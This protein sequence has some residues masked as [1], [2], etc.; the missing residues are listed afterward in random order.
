MKR[1]IVTG[2]VT[3]DCNIARSRMPGADGVWS[4]G[5]SSRLYARPGGA[6]LLAELVREL[7]RSEAHVVSPD[8]PDPSVLLQTRECTHSYA[9]WSVFGEKENR[10]WRVAEF[11][12][13][14]K[15]KLAEAGW[16]RIADT[17]GAAVTVID[18][19]NL[20]FRENPEYWPDFRSSRWIVLKTSRQVGQGPLFERLARDHRER[21]IVVVSA[22]DL[23]QRDVRISRAISWEQ[24]AE[25]LVRELRHRDGVKALT[26]C[27]AAVVLFPGAGAFLISGAEQRLFFDPR[28]ME[29]QWRNADHGEAIGYTSCMAAALALTLLRAPDD[30]Q[31]DAAIQA[32]LSAMRKLWEAGYGTRESDAAKADLA[33]PLVTVAKEIS[34]PQLHVGSAHVPPDPAGWSILAD[35]PDGF[36]NLALALVNKGE[37][38]LRDIPVA[39]FGKLTAIDR[40]EIESYQAMR[41]LLAEYGR[42]RRDK[43]ISVAVF[44]QPG[45]GKSF[46]VKELANSLPG[47]VKDVEFNLSQF[48]SPAELAAAFHLV[49]DIG[50]SGALPLV[51]WD[52]FDTGEFSWLSWFLAPMQDG[53]FR[54]GETLHPIGRAIFVFAGGVCH[55][56]NDFQKKAPAERK[57]PDFSSRFRGYIDISSINPSPVESDRAYPIRRALALRGILAKRK[58]EVTI[59]GGI[60]NALLEV[61]AYKHGVRSMEAILDMS[62]LTGRGVFEQSSLPPSRLLDLHVDASEFEA[63]LEMEKHVETMAE[64]L[65]DTYQKNFSS[66]N[67]LR[68]DDMPEDEKD[69][70]REN[71]RDIPRKLAIVGKRIAR[72]SRAGG[73]VLSG[74]EVEML[75]QR[76]HERWM[77]LKLR[78][79]WRRARSTNKLKKLHTNIVE[80]NRLNKLAKD[81]DRVLVQAIPEILR[82][83]GLTIAPITS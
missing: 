65:H 68:Y 59:D 74:T 5:I 42:S 44:G 15:A 57:G 81:K 37:A 67:A 8:V 43:P 69:Q 49:R 12:G 39:K 22:D 40:R 25:D 50:L 9:T 58:L 26:E 78:Q 38:A 27:H 11:L 53:L 13:L 60:L 64:E 45:S 14:D 16:M 76:E 4:G 52:E 55:T 66:R 10:G 20:G 32:G 21:L 6:A 35:H 48:R 75:A 77:Q 28:E 24:T 54:E 3:L 7:A 82:Q 29:G 71:V 30:L 70:N 62:A 17:S 51:F 79:G 34:A 80:W 56:M 41:G 61:S 19:A 18:D 47:A 36:H 46:G 73:L 23:R 1:V 72:A 31:F 2:D 63:L 33:F 83:C